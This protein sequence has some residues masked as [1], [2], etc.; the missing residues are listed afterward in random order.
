M[1]RNYSSSAAAKRSRWSTI[2]WIAGLLLVVI[3]L[4]YYQQIAVLYVLSTLGVTALLIIVAMADLTG[5]KKSDSPLGDDSAALGSGITANNS[6][7]GS[8]Q[9]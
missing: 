5:R 2:G 6:T 7:F 4:L 3:A 1:S 8:G 9:R